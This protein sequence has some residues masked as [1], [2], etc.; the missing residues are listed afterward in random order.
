MKFSNKS[1]K[2]LEK[3]KIFQRKTKLVVLVLVI[4]SL[5]AISV[6]SYVRSQLNQV[7]PTISLKEIE[8]CETIYYD[9]IEDVYGYVTRERN[10][11]GICIYYL[12]STVCDDEPLNKSCHTTT[13]EKEY[14]C[15]TGKE[16]YQSYEKIDEKVVK[17][18]KI[19]C[20][21]KKYL[22]S[23][24]KKGVVT[25]NEL[26][27]SDFGPCIYE[28]ENNCLIVTCVSRYDGAHKGQFTDC[29]GGKSCQKFEICDDSIRTF[30]KNSREDFVE[31]DPTFYLNKL[32]LKEVSE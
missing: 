12:N 16:S 20:T 18:N 15:V 14:Q 28:V 13:T 9:E 11:Y 24:D 30:Y 3:S 26:D 7:T 2:S 8:D 29:K 1:E 10:V 4:I 23:V 22:V 6:F 21:P 25:K 32:A 17:K 31:D 5:L 27:F 19:E